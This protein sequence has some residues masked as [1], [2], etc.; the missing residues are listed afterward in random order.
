MKYTKRGG[1]KTGNV[2]RDMA[3]GLLLDMQSDEYLK[4]VCDWVQMYWRQDEQ[5]ETA[6]ILRA[7]K[8][9]LA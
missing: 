5:S 7:V 6:Q 4:R 9:A 3:M 8:E 1:F 2:Y